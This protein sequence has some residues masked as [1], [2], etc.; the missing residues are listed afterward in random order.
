M[1]SILVFSC[2]F[3]SSIAGQSQIL[4]TPAPT[5]TDTPEPPVCR[6]PRFRMIA[7]CENLVY[8]DKV[9]IDGEDK[10]V[11]YNKKTQAPY[12]GRCKVCHNNGNLWMLLEYKNG[13]SFGIDT[14]YYEN[15]NINLI[16]SHD[17]QGLG[18]EDGT[19][20]FYRED[21]TLKWEKT[22]IMGAADGEQRYYFPDSTLEKVE[23]WKMGQLNGKKQEYY[24]GGAIRKEIGYKNGKF[25]GTY[26]TY[27]KDGKVE[28]EQQ[29]LNDKKIGPSSYYYESGQLFYTENH[30]NGL[31]EG[32][33]KRFY[34]SGRKWTVE[35]Y[36][37]GVRSGIFE[38]YYDDEKNTLKYS[39]VYKKGVV[40]EEHY[41]DEFG[42]ETA[43]PAKEGEK[44]T[45][46]GGQ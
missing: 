41:Y 27:F 3:M 11:V 46:E 7:D 10:D 35:N 38:E 22:F 23:M 43:P 1:K 45:P 20:K 9:N 8:V 33:C 15:G 31:L 36:K 19:W 13:W 16:R 42:D 4:D 30:E 28:S 25:D 39:A 24:P 5:K 34:M 6:D 14:V 44:T 21:G 18:K 40:V 26:V 12:S 2:L 37:K 32:E 29:Y 17:T